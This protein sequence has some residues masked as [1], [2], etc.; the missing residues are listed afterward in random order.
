MFVSKLTDF[1]VGSSGAISDTTV[2]GND[3]IGGVD[4]SKFTAIAIGGNDTN[5]LFLAPPS[6]PSP[7]VSLKVDYNSQTCPGAGQLAQNL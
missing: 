3:M 7:P 6:P 5:S 1:I 2:N 4:L